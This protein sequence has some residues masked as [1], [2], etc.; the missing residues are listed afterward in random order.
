VGELNFGTT[1]IVVAACLFVVDAL[2]ATRTGAPPEEAV[3]GSG[4]VVVN[5]FAAGAYVELRN[6]SRSTVDI[7]GFNLWLCGSGVVATELRMS[8]GQTLSPGDFYIVASSSFTGA[9]ADQIYWG[10]LPSGGAM[11]LDPDYGWVDGIAV[12]T[13]SPCGEG[14]PA[15][16][17]GQASTARDAMGTDTGDNATDFAC[18]ARSPGT[19]NL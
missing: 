15:P 7:S 10:V 14:R 3:A 13:R 19:V 2:P 8:L 12:A 5:E 1:A 4:V 17:C 11:L 6:T 16:A 18:R 9:P